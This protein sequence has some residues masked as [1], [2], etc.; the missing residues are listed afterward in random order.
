MTIIS[1]LAA[2]A[3]KVVAT[4]ERVLWR[5]KWLVQRSIRKPNIGKALT[6]YHVRFAGSPRAPRASGTGSAVE[7]NQ[8]SQRGF[9]FCQVC[10]CTAV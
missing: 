1:A 4:H 6:R 10:S 8:I 7:G 5:A 9:L 2:T 3:S